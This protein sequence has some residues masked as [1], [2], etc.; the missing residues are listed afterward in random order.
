LTID[1]KKISE[2][3]KG[4]AAWNK[5][6]KRK[7]IICPNCGKEGGD[8]LMQRWHFDNCKKLKNEQNFK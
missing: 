2:S 7:K 1:I 8:G 6:L 4:S 5:G 3:K